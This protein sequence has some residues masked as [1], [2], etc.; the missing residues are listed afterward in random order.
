M[1][2]NCKIFILYFVLVF[3]IVWLPIKLISSQCVC[4]FRAV[5]SVDELPWSVVPDILHLLW[6]CVI[7]IMTTVTMA[8][9]T[10]GVFKS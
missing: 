5:H 2:I 10:M 3:S 1:F 9:V 8:T 4:L 6:S 7:V